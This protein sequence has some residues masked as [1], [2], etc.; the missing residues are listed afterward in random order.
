MLKTTTV[1]SYPRK[2]KP[3]DTLRKPSVSEEEAFEMI[4]WAV[5]DQC[6]LGLNFI[7]DGEFYSWEDITKT[8]ADKMSV[9]ARV[10][11]IPEGILSLIGIIFELLAIFS[12]KPA[13]F[14]RQRVIDIRQSSWTASPENFFRDFVNSSIIIFST[15]LSEFVTKS[16][17]P[18]EDTCNFSSSPK[19]LINTLEAFSAALI[20]IFKFGDIEFIVFIFFLRIQ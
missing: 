13:L 4:E 18:F 16:E 9:S 3:K 5:K 15:F 12:S 1:G 8:A 7:T 10:L 19:S 11:K 2:N 20:I 14:D 17:G 6:E